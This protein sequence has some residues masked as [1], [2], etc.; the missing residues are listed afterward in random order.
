MIEL[1]DLIPTPESLLRRGAKSQCVKPNDGSR[2]S[3]SDTLRKYGY[4]RKNPDVYDAICEYG[5]MMLEGTN[6]KGLFLKG[7]VGIGKSFGV[8]IL[9][10]RFKIPVFTPSIFLSMYKELNG[11][12]LRLEEIVRSGNHFFGAPSD[13][14]IDELGTKDS[15]R[16][17]GESVDLMCDVLDMR[18]RAFIRDGVK[19][20]VTTNLSDAELF[21]RYGA[22]ID[23]RLNE[24][25][26]FRSVTGASLR[27]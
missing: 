15:T 16:N 26:Y 11:N 1:R 24:M 10:M 4:Q 25:F 8:E 7:G 18:Y 21:S 17:F 27:G 22:R 14:V 6:A 12:L 13:I 9:A 5:A 23:D 3:I 19:T 20:V 2:R